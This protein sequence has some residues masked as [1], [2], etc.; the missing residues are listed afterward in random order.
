M[1]RVSLSSPLSKHAKFAR[2][3]RGGWISR[4]HRSGFAGFSS[5]RERASGGWFEWEIGSDWGQTAARV[6]HGFWP[7]EGHPAQETAL[8]PHRLPA[9]DISQRDGVRNQTG[10]QQIRWELYQPSLSFIRQSAVLGSTGHHL[11]IMCNCCLFGS[12]FIKC[13]VPYQDN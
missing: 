13:I 12:I 4:E 5:I 10:P 11:V 7:P 1:K 8:L 6:A 9:G 3:G 2:H